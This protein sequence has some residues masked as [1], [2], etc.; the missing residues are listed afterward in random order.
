MIRKFCAENSLDLLKYH[1]TC[2]MMNLYCYVDWWAKLYDLNSKTAKPSL[3]SQMQQNVTVVE[4]AERNSYANRNQ[5]SVIDW[6]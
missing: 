6:K 3:F 5:E 1:M 2:L 4:I